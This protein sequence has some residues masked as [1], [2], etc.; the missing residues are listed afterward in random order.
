MIRM[1]SDNPM[2]IPTAMEVL[3]SGGIVAF[4]TDTVYGLGASLRHTEAI[5]RMFRV[6]RRPEEMAIPLL[7]SKLE[8][9]QS[10]AMEVSEEAM[11]LARCFWPGP[12]TMVLRRHPSVPQEIGRGKETVAV[13]IPDHPLAL[14]LIEV[15]GGALAVTS[16]N[17]SGGDNPL[18][19][20]DVIAQLGDS[21]DLVLDGNCPGGT[22]S[23]IV[24]TTGE[25]PAI[26]RPGPVSMADLRR[27]LKRRGVG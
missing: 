27:C 21:V 23:T 6:K 18:S 12:L 14:T 15:S 4:P 26:L 11:L 17:V 2:A 7:L 8:A 22:P 16:A 19:A 3:A 24:D 5:L 10:V 20:D 13:R 25:Q 1:G 9:L